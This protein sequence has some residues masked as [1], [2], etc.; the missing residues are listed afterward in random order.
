MV[1]GAIRGDHF[2][3]LGT[4]EEV[5]EVGAASVRVVPVS[6]GSDES[7][8]DGNRSTETVVSGTVGREHLGGCGIRDEIVG[9]NGTPAE[10][11][12]GCS[13]DE[14]MALNGEGG[15]KAWAGVGECA[16]WCAGFER[17]D[18][19]SRDAWSADVDGVRSEGDGGSEVLVNGG[20]W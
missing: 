12:T 7:T 4:G 3:D 9:V 1:C 5:K 8:A 11:V 15:A 13:D 19:D 2:G 20:G 17:K 10:V 16:G 14:V 18:E 6:T